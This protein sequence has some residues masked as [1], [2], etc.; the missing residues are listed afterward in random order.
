MYNNAI[1]KFE[2][3][4]WNCSIN[5]TFNVTADSILNF[6]VSILYLRNKFKIIKDDIYKWLNDIFSF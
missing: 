2:G 6:F 4:V 3:L 5:N 1:D